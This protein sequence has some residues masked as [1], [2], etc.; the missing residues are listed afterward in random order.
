MEMNSFV[1][2]TTFISNYPIKMAVLVTPFLIIRFVWQNRRQRG[3]RWLIMGMLL[4]ALGE[5]FCGLNVWV[6]LR[7]V[8]AFEFLHG[9]GMMAG[10]C[11]FYVGT[12]FLVEDH[13]LFYSSRDKACL[14]LRFCKKKAKKHQ[15]YSMPVIIKKLQT[16]A[17]KTNKKH[18]KH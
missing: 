5:A 8:P 9:L 7:M 2:L 17:V 3:F 10:L 13:L 4:F 1:A 12:Y 6:V 18:K 16:R 15:I 14:M 11:S